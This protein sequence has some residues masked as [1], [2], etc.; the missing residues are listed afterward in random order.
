MNR[1]LITR[2]QKQAERMQALLQ[3]EGFSTWI[4]PVLTTVVLPLMCDI[5]LDA[6]DACVTTSASGVECLA[7][8]TTCRDI[9]IFCA[10]PAS[11]GTAKEFGFSVVFCA[12]E[13]GGLALVHLLKQS[14]FRNVAYVHGEQVKI[15][16][17]K[18]CLTL[19]INVD[20]FCLYK[21]VPA[22]QWSDETV[23]FFREREIYALTFYSEKSASVTLD[24]L[25]SHNLFS[26]TDTIHALC[27]SPAIA[28]IISKQ[29]WKNVHIA[30]T[31]AE[32]IAILRNESNLVIQS[33]L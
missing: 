23:M 31:S 18:E 17:A 8:I 19:G 20:S 33:A 7:K 26:Y 4:D 16:I 15:D 10:G 3:A 9:P 21:T 13:L 12:N 28:A 32:L 22:K 6:Y 14:C 5:N 1:I 29:L 25:R 24:L 30:S 11:A 2:P 27:L